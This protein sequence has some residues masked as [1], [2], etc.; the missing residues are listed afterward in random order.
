MFVEPVK[1]KRPKTVM[2]S[3]SKSLGQMRPILGVSH[4]G[5]ITDIAKANQSKEECIL[6]TNGG[7]VLGRKPAVIAYIFQGCGDGSHQTQMSDHLSKKKLNSWKATGWQPL[8]ATE[9]SP[10]LL[11][12][13]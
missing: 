4:F 7:L 6:P 12:L 8:R 13:L 3:I 10:S 5:A 2:I 11:G 1:L 9:L